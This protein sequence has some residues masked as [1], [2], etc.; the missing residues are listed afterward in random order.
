MPV[1]GSSQSDASSATRLSATVDTATPLARE[2]PS[3]GNPRRFHV[4]RRPPMVRILRELY[5]YRALLYALTQRELKARYR[6][7]SLGFLWTFL[8]PTLLMLVYA[9]MFSVLLKNNIPHSPY[10]VFVG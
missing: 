3:R 1:V 7:S 10:F 6:G 4:R 8:N 2:T 5:Q 9:F